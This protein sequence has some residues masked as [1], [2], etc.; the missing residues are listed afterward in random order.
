MLLPWAEE[1]L[2]GIP[3]PPLPP[4]MPSANQLFPI[5]YIAQLPGASTDELRDSPTLAWMLA[6][7]DTL[8]AA[9]ATQ[10]AEMRG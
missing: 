5:D 4:G 8:P 3:M 7:M 6:N 9:P 2:R 10:R 1:E